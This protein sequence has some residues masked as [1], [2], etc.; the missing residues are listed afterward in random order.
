MDLL[1]TEVFSKAAIVAVA[2]GLEYWIGP[3]SV[4]AAVKNYTDLSE[5]ASVGLPEAGKIIGRFERLLILLFVLTGSVAGVGFLLTAKSVFR[6]GDL[7]DDKTHKRAEYYL[8]GTLSSFTFGLS[9]AYAAAWLLEQ[10]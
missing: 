2:V 10:I 6:F 3:L 5:V 9:I 7:K 4:R 1:S 8:I